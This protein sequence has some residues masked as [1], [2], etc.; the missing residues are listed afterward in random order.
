M[1]RTTIDYGID[2]G[3]TNSK[4]A[5]LRDTKPDVIENQEGAVLTPSAVWVD[6]KGTIRVGRKAKERYEEDP[7]NCDM[8]FKRR[9]GRGHEGKKVFSASGQAML[10]EELSAEVLKSLRADVRLRCGEDIQAAVITVPADFELP[11]CDAT[12]KAAELAGFVASPLLQEPVAAAL[13]Y[14]FQSKSDK[15]FWIAYDLGGGTFDAAVIQVRD[16]MVQVVNHAGDN[17]LGGKDVDWEIVEKELIP[18]L[19]SQYHLTDFRRGNPKWKHALAKLKLAAEEAKIQVSRSETSHKIWIESLCQGERG[20]PVELE[21]DLTLDV[22]DKLAAPYIARSI[23]LCRKAIQEKRLSTENIEKVLMVG[24]TSLLPLIRREVHRALGVALECGIDPLTVVARGAAV[25]AGTQLLRSADAT[26]TAGQ[27]RI[28]LEYEP[29]GTDTDPLV[30]GRVIGAAGA[31]LKGFTVELVE[32]KSQWR[33]GKIPVA[34]N[35]AFVATVHAEKERRCEFVIELCDP[36]GTRCP[37]VP[38]R[39]PYTVGMA[40]ANAP[41][42][43]A[44]HV[45]LANNEVRCFFEKGTPL[46][47]RVTKVLKQAYTA[48]KGQS[49]DRIA[50]PVVEGTNRR[51]DRNHIIGTMVIEA[52]DKR[53]KRDVPAGSDVEITI[54]M[55]ESRIASTKAFVPVLDEEFEAVFEDHMDAPTV[56]QLQEDCDRETER[57]AEVRQKA[58]RVGDL[59]AA[60]ALSRIDREQIVEQV[61]SGLRAAE[62]DP[63]APLECH[64][65]MLSLKAAI[66][67]AEDAMEWPLLVEEAKGK[68]R[69]VTQWTNEDGEPEEKRQLRLLADE[70]QKAIDSGDA[71]VL[72]RRVDELTS[73]GMGVL[74]RKPE[75]W[76]GMFGYAEERRS[77]MTD[78]RLA[79]Q[80]LAQGRRAINNQDPEALEGAVRQLMG[81][82]PR[83]QQE[84]V[85]R[86]Y[87]GSTIL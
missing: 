73:L 34:E 18:L 9:M 75:F 29:I 10:P 16:G 2:L 70:T 38:E 33:S 22:L 67:E 48:R 72:R 24:G 69:E 85:R 47:A 27:F 63:D 28:E 32:A 58:N 71:D 39:F 1:A 57:L 49:G 76:V 46:P 68:V 53:F 43:H 83:E 86:K 3:T 82:L 26:L 59:K 35:G 11:Q 64:K 20:E 77:M 74:V 36:R 80:L 31:A 81:L 7:E 56:S 41:L 42:T 79:D 30:G 14:G 44:I 21:Y 50:F 66:D 51:A 87:G 54:H 23:N 4:I 13:A 15:V 25:F 17:F 78:E 45:G 19:T 52:T 61:E 55:D 40:P 65:R 6:K 8:E 62:G 84:E 5:V 60:E 37:T 12:R